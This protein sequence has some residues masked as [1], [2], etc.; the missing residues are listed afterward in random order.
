MSAPVNLY[1]AFGIRDHICDRTER[2]E[3]ETVYHIRRNPDSLRCPQCQS[4]AILKR[5]VVVRRMRHGA[6]NGR[7]I[8]FSQT[9]QRVYCCE[10]D[11]IR[12]ADNPLAKPY[13]RHTNG[14][15]LYAIELCRDMT[16]LAAARH[17]GVD[18][19]V[20]KEILKEHLRKRFRCI[21][22]G[23]LRRIAIDE[24]YT[25]KRHKFITIV[26]DL[27]SGAVVYIGQGKGMESLGD[28]WKKLKRS[29]AEIEA[30]ASDMSPAYTLAIAEKL[31]NAAHVFDRFHVVKLMNDK[32]TD[33]RRCVYR[34]ATAEEKDVIKGSRFLLV[35]NP[36]NLRTDKDEAK[37]L[38]EA[39]RINKDLNTAYYLKEDLRMLWGQ[40]TKARAEKHLDAWIRKAK[41]SGIR[42]LMTMAK[43][44]NTCR[45]GLL[46]WYDHP[47]SSG[48]LEGV[49]N[50]I[51]A[52]QRQAY[53]YR[54]QEF[55]HLKIYAAHLTSYKLVG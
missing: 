8:I 19:E 23:K 30:V 44:L 10:C 31:P 20:I 54:D 48:K 22:L 53:G 28:F 49:N 26:L 38:E 34:S 15:A 50:K 9:I 40:G 36:E 55:F 42:Q 43:T 32:L 51:G 27:D 18:D 14:F 47:I 33:L 7:P 35:K 5:G 4:A 29:G 16:M 39:L 45:A 37:H 11:T 6:T 52:I 13:V 3:G 1:Q 2:L 12:Q 25:G 46:A 17:L 41:V 24:I 21:R